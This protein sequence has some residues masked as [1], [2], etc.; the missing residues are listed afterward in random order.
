MADT[1]SKLAIHVGMNTAALRRGQSEVAGILG[2]MRQQVASVFVGLTGLS[3]GG[4]AGFGVRLAAEMEQA[5]IAFEVMI[6]DAERAKRLFNDLKDF[7]VATPFEFPEL[8]DSARTLLAMGIGVDD[9][10][11]NIKVLGDVSAG[12]N[13]PLN[14]LAGVFGQVSVAGRLT[15]NELRQ[16]NERGIPLMDALATRFGTTKAAIREMVEAGKISFADVE[17]AMASMAGEGGRFANLMGRQSQTLAGRFSTL[18]DSVKLAAA[19]FGTALAPA[20]SKAI[21][22]LIPLANWFEK[23]SIDTIQSTVKITAWGSSLAA[24]AFIVPRIVQGV[25][26]LTSALQAMARA[27]TI[28]LALSGPKGWATLAA[29]L[30]IAAGAAYALDR[31]F[32]TVGQSAAASAEKAGSAFKSQITGQLYTFSTVAGEAQKETER[33]MAEGDAKQKQRQSAFEARGK[34]LSESLRTPMEEYSAALREANDLLQAGAITEETY[35]RAVAK[36]REE[37]E[38]KGKEADRTADKLRRMN[39]AAKATP[40]AIIA[41]TQAAQSALANRAN[42]EMARQTAILERIDQKLANAPVIKRASL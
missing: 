38:A 23:L 5:G 18:S 1:I 29:G 26:A 13:Q 20:L 4:A 17:A 3:L 33:Q 16:F 39:D 25:V 36:A 41:G 35:S 27:Q 30:G 10:M 31:A 7:A 32:Q 2:S 42:A 19:S 21:E 12:T 40:T 22:A 15:G 9:V 6:G 14:E 34:Q 37:L 24:A 8:R 28:T 11:R